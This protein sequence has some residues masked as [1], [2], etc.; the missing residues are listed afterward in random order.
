M[1]SSLINDISD[2][3]GEGDDSAIMSGIFT[4][5]KSRNT[6]SHLDLLQTLEQAPVL[7]FAS[8]SNDK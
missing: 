8:S 5:L 6:S 2:A 1:I 3:L 4:F 7:N